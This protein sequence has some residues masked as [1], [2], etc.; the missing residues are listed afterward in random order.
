M[1]AAGALDRSFCWWKLI[2]EES[3]FAT[4]TFV[5]GMSVFA[6]KDPMANARRL[7]TQAKV[8]NF[9]SI[10]CVINRRESARVPLENSQSGFTALPNSPHLSPIGIK[11]V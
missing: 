1:G 8:K 5:T 2:Y 11:S 4:G 10:S 3:A 6:D 9:I 7:A